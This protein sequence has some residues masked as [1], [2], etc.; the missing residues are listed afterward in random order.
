MKTLLVN[1]IVAKDSPWADKIPTPPIGLLSIAAVL[2][3][4]GYEVEVIDAELEKLDQLSLSKRIIDI[5]PEIVGI[6]TDSC[7]INESLRVAKVTKNAT[8]AIVIMGGPHTSILP[9]N[10]IQY[11]EVDI[12]VIGEG[13]YTMLNIVDNLSNQGS[14]KNCTGIWYKE[15][16]KVIKN[17]RAERI[18]EL[19]DLPFPARHLVPMEKYP[20]TYSISGLEEPVDIINTS[21]GCPYDCNFCS[22]RIIWGSMYKTRHPSLVIQEIEHLIEHYGTKSI[23][24]REDNFMV[25]HRRVSEICDEIKTRGIKIS[26][27]CSSRVDQVESDLL[28]KMYE[29]GCQAIWYGIESGSS[30]TLR[31]LNKKISLEQSKKAIRLSKEAGLKVGASF[32]FGVPGETLEDIDQSIEFIKELNCDFICYNHFCAIPIS[33]MYTE[34]KEKKLIDSVYGDILFVKTDEFDRDHIKDIIH[35]CQSG[36]RI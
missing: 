14:L 31:K 24:F 13:E 30:D 8:D 11:P 21:R 4:N 15:N 10:V 25:N 27:E 32:M 26:W 16:D 34:V 20:R 23:V 22:S 2:E 29:S 5:K 3:E 1:P 33:K 6:T 19:D 12:V 28:K 35:Q 36:T 9:D 18:Y 7:N 17:Q